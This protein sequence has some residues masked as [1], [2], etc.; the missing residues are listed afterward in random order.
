MVQE[1]AK[2]WEACGVRMVYEGD[3]DRAPGVMDGRNVIG[4]NRDMPSQLRGI[5]Q[6]RAR[7]GTF[8]E[9]DIALRPDRK[10]FEPFPRLLRKVI[11]H[12]FGDAIG[13][14]HSTRC[15]DVMTLAGDCPRRNPDTLPLAPTANDLARCHVLYPPIAT[16]VQ[17]E[18]SPRGCSRCDQR[19]R[20]R[21]CTRRLVRGSLSQAAPVKESGALRRPRSNAGQSHAARRARIRATCRAQTNVSDRSTH[22]SVHRLGRRVRCEL[23]LRQRANARR[24]GIRQVEPY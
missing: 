19:V 4:W 1:A 12:E 8:I 9:R 13:L 20:R 11:A 21:T 7:I 2:R 18:K 3:M 16:S 23:R 15:D 17:N 22:L 6:G 5:T 24:R 10:E 14:T